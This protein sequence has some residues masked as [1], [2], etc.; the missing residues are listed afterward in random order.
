MSSPEGSLTSPPWD[1]RIGTRSA[2]IPPSL[3]L[4]QLGAFAVDYGAPKAYS[5]DD[6]H[7]L[8]GQNHG[9]TATCTL[10]AMD[11]FRSRIELHDLAIEPMN[12][13]AQRPV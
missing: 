13:E 4:S 11:D 9:G 2:E 8:A 3:K 6:S 1:S 12:T 10:C 7:V 5:G